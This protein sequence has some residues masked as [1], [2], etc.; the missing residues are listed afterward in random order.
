MRFANKI[1]W[2]TG[3]GSGLGAALA[4]EL[5]KQGAHI[6]LS[7]RRAERLQA[8]AQ[9]LQALGKDALV[10]PCDVIR[11]LPDVAH[12]WTTVIKQTKDKCGLSSVC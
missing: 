9:Q 4:L 3:G 2:I 10:V 6:A 8:V 11:R 7:G 12:I 1:V 5:A